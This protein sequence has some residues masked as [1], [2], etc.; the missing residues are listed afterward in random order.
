MRGKKRNALVRRS[1]REG[2]LVAGPAIKTGS[3][4]STFLNP[5]QWQCSK[6]ARAFAHPQAWKTGLQG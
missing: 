5:A 2:A 6:L 3:E 1:C 4:P